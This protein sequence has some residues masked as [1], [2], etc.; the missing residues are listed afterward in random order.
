MKLY[1]TGCFIILACFIKFVNLPWLTDVC[2]LTFKNFWTW[3]LYTRTHREKF[4]N[5]KVQTLIH[6]HK[7][8]FTSHTL[9]QPDPEFCKR[10]DE[11][12]GTVNTLKSLKPVGSRS[13]SKSGRCCFKSHL[14]G[15]VWKMLLST[16]F[17]KQDNWASV[18]H[19]CLLETPGVCWRC[20]EFVFW[21]AWICLLR[22]WGSAQGMVLTKLILYH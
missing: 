10:A 16:E 9:P 11:S 14:A 18:P 15:K 22:C 7:S 12:V 6:Y 8:S 17:S 20:W 3:K 19:R 1:K 21:G 2:L 5:G 4:I 13:I